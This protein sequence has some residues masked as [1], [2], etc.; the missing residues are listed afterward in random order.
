MNGCSTAV[1]G[2][3]HAIIVLAANLAIMLAY[4][5]MVEARARR[6]LG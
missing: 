1:W 2:S 4:N 3:G 6:T 5:R